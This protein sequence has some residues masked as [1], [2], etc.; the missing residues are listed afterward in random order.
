MSPVVEA[1]VITA[2]PVVV[3]LEVEALPRTVCPVTVNPPVVEA[4]ARTV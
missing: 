1:F 4:L 2:R 3:K